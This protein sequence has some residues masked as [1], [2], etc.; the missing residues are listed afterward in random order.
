[1]NAFWAVALSLAMGAAVGAING[2]LIVK[3]KVPD[4]LAALGMMFLLVGAQRIPTEGRS[5]STGMA[6]PDGSIANGKFSE[7]FLMLG[8]YRIGDLVP[9]SVVFLVVI[10]V[11]V[12]VF[13]ETTRHR[14]LMYA[15]GSNAAA[16]NL[17]GAN[18]NRYKVLAYMISGAL[19]SVGGVLL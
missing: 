6:L 13:F 14:R 5:I 11:L 16:A 3:M 2:W 12:W 4:L 15:I 7:A 18:V 19:A 9:L 8:R 17:A 10:A 1:M